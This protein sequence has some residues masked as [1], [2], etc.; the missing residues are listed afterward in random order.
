[1]MH[2]LTNVIDTSYRS[3]ADREPVFAYA[4]DFGNVSSAAVTYTIGSIQQPA[5]KYVSTAGISRLDPWWAQCYGSVSQMI[6][7]HYNDLA[8]TQQLAAVFESQLKRDVDQFYSSE[9]AV[10][11]S[12]STPQVG[13]VNSNGSKG[14]IQ[15]VDQYRH[16]YI[17]DPQ[18]AYGFLDPE[19]FSGIA[20][21]DV[22][23]AE[24]YYSI[25]AL[26]AR[27]VMGAYV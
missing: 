13:P 21:P 18:T 10:V 15:G 20:I 1:M 19:S 4:H 11:F 23:E 2:N 16:Q 3:S 27:Q 14:F 9:K 22:S 7:F 25:I 17:F 5:I 26:S 6:S 8:S 12:N 24:S